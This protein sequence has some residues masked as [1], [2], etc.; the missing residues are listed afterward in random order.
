MKTKEPVITTYRQILETMDPEW[1]AKA[2]ALKLAGQTTIATPT[3][4]PYRMLSKQ[5]ILVLSILCPNT[6]KL[7]EFDRRPL[8]LPFLN[9][10]EAIETNREVFAGLNFHICTSY[11]NNLG[12]LR[13][14]SDNYYD[15]KT[16]IA[17]SWGFDLDASL[18]ELTS[19]AQS[20]WI[21]HRRTILKAIVANA[22]R[23]L[24]SLE[25]G[26]HNVF[27]SGKNWLP[28]YESMPTDP[29]ERS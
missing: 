14:E 10:I 16:W 13:L 6:S 11:N 25:D 4:N 3:K 9:E 5:E 26:V 24:A 29:K 12:F 27:A 19:L 23:D 15:K 22:S 7:H 28:E 2:T 21:K 18:A 20:Q 17:A 1:I 8:P